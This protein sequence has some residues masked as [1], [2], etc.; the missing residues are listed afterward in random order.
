MN[1][2]FAAPPM[3]RRR[4]VSQLAAG[5]ATL[6]V[7]S[8]AHGQRGPTPKKLG[9]ALVGLGGYATGQLGPALKI[10]ENCRLAGVVTGSREKGRRWAQEFGFPEKNVFSYDTMAQ[11][12]DVPDIDIVYVVTPN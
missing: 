2:P 11:I 5:A 6:A 4:F 1:P 3:S 7:A 8:R 9:V 12:A 10:T